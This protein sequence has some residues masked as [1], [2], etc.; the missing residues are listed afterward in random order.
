[1]TQI[2]N[3]ELIK[4]NTDDGDEKVV[5]HIGDQRSPDGS[6]EVEYHC[7]VCS[8]VFDKVSKLSIIWTGCS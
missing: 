6:M 8:K 3:L 4:E 5:Q 2:D 1:M 7:P